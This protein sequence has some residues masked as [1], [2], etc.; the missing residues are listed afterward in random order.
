MH[1]FFKK[2]NFLLLGY[3]IALAFQIAFVVHVK[4]L[5]E[6]YQLTD[7]PQ[8]KRA[9]EHHH[10]LLYSLYIYADIKTKVHPLFV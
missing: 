1:F 2:N 4:L 9:V 3:T 7:N 8:I 5:Y 10:V 6:N